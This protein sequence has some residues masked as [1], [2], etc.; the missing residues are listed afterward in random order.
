MEA[1]RLLERLSGEG[2]NVSA[3]VEQLNRVLDLYRANRTDEADALLVQV[4]NQLRELASQLPTFRLHKWLQIGVSVTALLAIP[5]LFYYFFPR[6][7]ALV[8]AYSRRN[9]LVRRV[10]RRGSRR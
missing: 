1:V 5:P 2:V 9:W 6:A 10:S 3:H 4:L 7:Y 8:W